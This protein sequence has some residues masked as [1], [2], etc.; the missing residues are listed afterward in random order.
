MI[1][2]R[3]NKCSGSQ[4]IKMSTEIVILT[5]TKFN[6]QFTWAYHYSGKYK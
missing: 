3:S 1:E 6:Y 5:I 4:I 2:I